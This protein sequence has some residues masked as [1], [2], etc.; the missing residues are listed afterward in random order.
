MRLGP[1][2]GS[3]VCAILVP[4]D[5]HGLA[6]TSRLSSTGRSSVAYSDFT[7]EMAESLIGGRAHGGDLFPGLAP[8]TVPDWLRDFLARGMQLALVS[9][10]ARS[11]LIVSPVLL[12]CRE[13]SDGKV[14]FFSGQRL[15][16][17]ASRGLVGECDFLLTLSD[18]LPRLRAP[19]V[20]LVAAKKLDI[21]AGM[22]QCIA[23]MVAARAFNE[24]E[25][26]T[27]GTIHGCVTT[28]ET[29]Q[30][31][32]LDGTSVIVDRIRLYI[33]NVGGILAMLRAIVLSASRPA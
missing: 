28:G 2:S 5:R 12:A 20:A 18:P 19:I 26:T 1:C 17:D 9:E 29:W 4:R 6:L 32:R 31:L 10:K 14:A 27:V 30:F 8:L 24:R 16:V 33:D 25:G 22:G 15:D 11:E 13:L 21:E 23:Q 3:F 7:L